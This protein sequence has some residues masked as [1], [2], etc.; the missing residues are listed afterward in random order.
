[1]TIKELVKS[2]NSLSKNLTARTVMDKVVITRQSSDAT[3]IV[4]KIGVLINN[5]TYLEPVELELINLMLRTQKR[6]PKVATTQ[7]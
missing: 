4:D 6:P 7:K 1:M 2:V 5:I 3:L